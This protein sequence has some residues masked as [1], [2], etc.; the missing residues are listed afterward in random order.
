MDSARVKFDL[1]RLQATLRRELLLAGV[2]S[3]AGSN[4]CS[5]TSS[6]NRVLGD[7]SP[8]ASAADLIS[9]VGLEIVDDAD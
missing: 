7:T 8:G 3:N 4:A 2:N 9:D 5:D 1:C 6:N